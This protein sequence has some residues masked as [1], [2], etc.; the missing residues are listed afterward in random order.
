MPILH[1]VVAK[2]SWKRHWVCE[3]L[4]FCD[5]AAETFEFKYVCPIPIF[6]FVASA[7]GCDVYLQGGGFQVVVLPL[8]VWLCE[9]L[10]VL[11]NALHMGLQMV[12]AMCPD[13][14][15]QLPLTGK[16]GWRVLAELCMDT[17]AQDRGVDARLWRW[18]MEYKYE[19]QTWWQRNHAT[20]REWHQ[21]PYN[22]WQT[23]SRF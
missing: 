5:K 9:R 7:D 12:G 18:P 3:W 1:S 13:V 4:T 17:N 19:G 2:A 10:P 11:Q 22:P 23:I 15:L 21:T 6:T 14:E 8:R 16:S 20:D